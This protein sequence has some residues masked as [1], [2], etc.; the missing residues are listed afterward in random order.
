MSTEEKLKVI[1]S[2]AVEDGQALVARLTPH[3][4]DVAE[5]AIRENPA[6][7]VSSA[8]IVAVNSDPDIRL[9]GI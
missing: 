9:S 6:I 5:R 1:A 2:A 3:Q 8:L 7:S 4:R